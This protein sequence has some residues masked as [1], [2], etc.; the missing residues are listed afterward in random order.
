MNRLFFMDKKT[1]PL[2][3]NL[4]NETSTDLVTLD[5]GNL[6]FAAAMEQMGVESVFDII[7]QSKS[8]FTQRLAEISNTD[9]DQAY[10]NAMC[11]A[12]QIGR[13]YREHV[14]S[15]GKPQT[16]TQESGIR[17][18]VDVGP[19]YANL[20]KENWDDFCKVGAIEAVD[21]PVAY[22]NRIYQLA[23][24]ELESQGEGQ[25]PKI[26]LDTRRPD[27]K[28]LVI[29]HQSTYAQIP[30]L[31][32]VN[33]VLTTGIEKQLAGTP[34]ESAPV[35]DL[36][37]AKRHPFLFPYNFPHHQATLGLEKKKYSGLGELNYQISHSLPIRQTPDNEFGKVQNPALEA[38]R[39][40]SGLSPE[41]QE[42]LIEP[43]LFT[44]FYLDRGEW[45]VA[46]A[47]GIKSPTP[48]INLPWQD[49]RQMAFLLPAQD[50]VGAVENG[51][52][53]TTPNI[54]AGVTVVAVELTFK[55]SE[56]ADFT[57]NVS[58]HQF[59]TTEINCAWRN[60]FGGV[61]ARNFVATYQTAKNPGFTLPTDADYKARFHILC[62]H[63]AYIDSSRVLQNNFLKQ[64]YTLS[65]NPFGYPLTPEEQAFFKNNYNVNVTSSLNNPLIELDVFMDKTGTDAETV[66]ALLSQKNHYPYVSPN[67][68]ITNQY[69]A[70]MAAFP[71]PTHY[72]A[73]YVNGVGAR[74]SGSRQFNDLNNAMGLMEETQGED[75]TWY[76]TQTSLNRFDR[77]QRMI[78]LQRWMNIPFAELDTLVISAMRAEREHNLGLDLNANTLRTLGVY[79]HLSQRYAIEPEEFAGFLHYICPFA[80]GDRTPLFDKVFNNSELFETP[81]VLDQTVFDLT[82]SDPATQKTIAQLCAGLQLQPTETSFFRLAKDTRDLANNGTLKR[83]LWTVSSLYRQARI[84]QLFGLSV[85]DCWALIDLLGGEA[86]RRNVASGILRPC[87]TQDSEASPA[88]APDILDILM[89]LD[90]AV[91]WLKETGQSVSA[92]RQQLGV[93]P[94]S[95]D[96]LSTL[97]NA[98][99]PLRKEMAEAF[100]FVIDLT[101]LN[102]PPTSADTE[103]PVDWLKDVLGNIVSSHGAVLDQPLHDT[104]PFEVALKDSL[105]G[106]MKKYVFNKDNPDQDA[107]IKA[108]IQER[109]G[110]HLMH[111]YALQ[112]RLLERLLQSIGSPPLDVFSIAVRWAGYTVSQLLA[113]ITNPIQKPNAV[114]IVLIA[115]RHASVMQHLGLGP[116]PLQRFLTTPSL[117]DANATDVRLS[118]SSL[119]LLDRYCRWVREAGKQD[120]D[121]LEYLKTANA[122]KPT[123]PSEDY[124]QQWAALLAALIQWSAPEVSTATRMLEDGVAKSMVEVDWV[125]R[126]Q[127]ASEY[128]GLSADSLLLATGLT[129]T[130]AVT[131]DIH[132]Q[133]SHE[134]W[135]ALG[136]A[137]MAAQRE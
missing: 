95:T 133:S 126:L 60:T 107:A 131:V 26:R 117:L 10:D 68:L 12:V 115:L 69:A 55:K 37:R 18:L 89:Q 28:E 80:T 109:L 24:K 123:A 64:T 105:L 72:G 74:E 93:D 125:R 38:Q 23:T 92:L 112:R 132:A 94:D 15:S 130:P 81:L 35:R 59:H 121:M 56:A 6:T 114:D 41:Q 58:L 134:A 7:R 61:Y 97:L 77:L 63:T 87:T 21:S 43:S 39:L 136:E 22:L 65:L 99:E 67:C 33:Q 47:Q 9:G 49:G 116:S 4:V 103:Q 66:Q 91:S 108:D 76:L 102:L 122:T 86:Y 53:L 127:R 20:F 111:G 45:E 11:Y 3:L 129:G 46:T 34:D 2:L 5:H 14:I 32:I 17:S 52:D 113:A 70:T 30:M 51:F 110:N 73:C 16:R 62:R 19:S 104:R 84:A 29:N 82:A 128:S 119:Y 71:F 8:T 13:A 88:N 83:D 50:G 48:G 135:R 44:T 106:N 57:C 118:L 90:W 124:A 36:M 98:M 40:M 85:E 31:D 100:A 96:I 27:L 78:R 42:L 79:R 75:K 137:V 54:N 25:H 1:N 120:K 101:H